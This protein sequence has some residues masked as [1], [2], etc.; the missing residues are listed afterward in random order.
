M[1]TTENVLARLSVLAPLAMG[2]ERATLVFTD[3]RIILAYVGKR[4]SRFLLSALGRLLVGAFKS[5]EEERRRKAVETSSPDELLAAD[6]SNFQVPYEEVVSVELTVPSSSG[7]PEL[8][9]VTKKEKL[10]FRLVADRAPEGFDETLRK[11][12]ADRFMVRR[13]SH[14]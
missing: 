2:F 6:P 13:P 8:T 7:M 10:L 14:F 12:L 9:V 3:S 5:G 4:S 11:I 1:Q